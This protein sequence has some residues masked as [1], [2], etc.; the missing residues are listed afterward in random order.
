MDARFL[1]TNTKKLVFGVQCK[2][3]NIAAVNNFLWQVISYNMYKN[4]SF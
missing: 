3:S 2:Y 1:N 4:N